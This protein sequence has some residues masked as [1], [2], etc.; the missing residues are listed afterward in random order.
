MSGREYNGLLLGGNDGM[1]SKKLALVFLFA[2]Q[3]FALA[4]APSQAEKVP[5]L[6]E[7][8]TV[9]LLTLWPGNEIYLAFGHSALRVRDPELHI[10]RT[11]N[12]GTFDLQDPLFIPK[13]VKGNLN[14]YLAHYAFSDDFHMDVHFEDRV[15]YEQVLNLDRDQA[16]EVFQFL[17]NNSRDELKYYRYDFIMDNCATRIRDVLIKTLGSDLRLDPENVRAPG[18]SFRALIDECVAERPFYRFMFFLV[19]GTASDKVPSSFESQFLPRCMMEVFDSSTILR[20]GKEEPLVRSAAEIYRPAK[21]M[22]RGDNYDPAFIIWPCAAFALA[23]T[24]W[25]F[26]RLRKTGKLPARRALFRFFDFLLFFVIGLLGCIVFYLAFFS[27]HA[28]AKGN[29]NTL[30]LLPT[31]LA[32]AFFL[33]RKKTMPRFLS[34]YFALLAL[35]CVVPL[36]F[37]PLWPQRM[38]LTMV[39]LMLMIAA[40]SAWLFVSSRRERLVPQVP[41]ERQAP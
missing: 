27:V 8:A 32:A 22:N 30:W 21:E 40:R 5:R 14:Y 16:T 29:L 39:P 35:L 18:K 37:W 19:L 23:F 11:F 20:N 17:M 26:I 13:F 4:A 7:S 6:S 9:S 15:W 36:A 34:W 28:A 3:A 33:L 25:N 41:R 38:S 31:N 12:Y 10:D 2:F 24:L 1:K